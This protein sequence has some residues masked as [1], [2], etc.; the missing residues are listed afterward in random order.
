MRRDASP[1]PT[2]IPI[3]DLLNLADEHQIDRVTI[4]GNSLLATTKQGHQYRAT[5]EDQQ[6]VTEQLRADNVAVSVIDTTNQGIGAGALAAVVP[7][8]I[9][10]ALIFLM[11]RR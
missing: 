2:L 10:L 8:L 7:L 1:T 11:S 6:S 9:I 3:S 4:A 5:K